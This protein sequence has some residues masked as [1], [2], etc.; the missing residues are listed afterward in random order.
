MKTYCF[1]IDGT[2]CEQKSKDYSLARPFP[3]RVAKVNS[4]YEQGNTIILFTARGSQSGIDWTKVTLAQLKSWGL[5]YHELI[6]GKPHAD[7]YVDDKAVNP[8]HFDW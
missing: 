5:R 6:T 4:L 7:V 8:E 1:D 3:E 2:L